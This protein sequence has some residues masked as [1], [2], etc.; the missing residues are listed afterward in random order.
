MTDGAAPTLIGSWFGTG[1]E[2]GIAAL[3]TIAGAVG[4]AVTALALASKAYRRLSATTAG[5][6]EPVPTEPDT[7]RSTTNL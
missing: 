4:V 1:P 7:S 6:T 5:A 2:R 3:F